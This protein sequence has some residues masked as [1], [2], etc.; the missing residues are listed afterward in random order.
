MGIHAQLPE[1]EAWPRSSSPHLQGGGENSLEHGLTDTQAH[2][3]HGPLP[4]RC[5]RGPGPCVPLSWQSQAAFAVS[6][7]EGE[8]QHRGAKEGV[9]VW[10]VPSPSDDGAECKLMA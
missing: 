3:H 9:V 10:T 8:G 7:C 2:Q 1:Q 4:L 5:Y 6:L